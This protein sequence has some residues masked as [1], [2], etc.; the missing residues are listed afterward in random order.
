MEVQNEIESTEVTEQPTSTEAVDSGESS[1]APP[2]EVY[3]PFASGK[4]KFKINGQEEEMD[5]ETAKRYVQFG[6]AGRQAMDKAAQLEKRHK[7]LHTKLGEFAQRDME[8]G[9]FLLYQALTGKAYNPKARAESVQ[10]PNSPNAPAAVDP[11]DEKL[12]L[13]EEKLSSFEQERE[14]ALIETERKA[15]ESELDEAV[16][17]FPGLD[18]KFTRSYIKSEYRKALQNGEQ[19]SIEDVA[20]FVAEEKKAQ[21]A[22]KAKATTER[23]ADNIKQSP[24]QTPAAAAPKVRKGTLEDAMRLGGVLSS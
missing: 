2:T 16:K 4:E 22:A 12:R 18:D 17:K 14:K 10:D 6:K 3:K 13:L 11:R 19:L 5:W 20:F 9:T 1:S 23:I 7:E 15:V 8:H 21:D 24:V